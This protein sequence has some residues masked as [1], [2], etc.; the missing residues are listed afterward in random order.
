MTKTT[1]AQGQGTTV[2]MVVPV[3]MVVLLVILLAE[4]VKND[5][6]SQLLQSHDERPVFTLWRPRTRGTQHIK[7]LK[8]T[9]QEFFLRVT[10]HSI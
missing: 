10:F 2:A 8:M 1:S 5:V 9:K 7:L 6:S 3:V 4:L